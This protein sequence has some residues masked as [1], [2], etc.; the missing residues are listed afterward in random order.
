[1]KTVPD[2]NPQSQDVTALQAMVQ[3]LID[4]CERLEIE[5]ISLAEQF[6][7]ALDRQFAKRAES[8]KP[9]DEAQGDL[10]NEVEQEATAPE[11]TEVK[12][13]PGKRKPLPT[14]LPRERIVLDLTD[15]EKVCACCQGELHK[16]VKV[17]VKSLNSSPRY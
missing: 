3:S 1:M 17:S 12:K 4:K 13:E 16:S 8:L 9:Y 15:E 6:K 11:Q 14:D 2:I 7:L 10:F 5:K